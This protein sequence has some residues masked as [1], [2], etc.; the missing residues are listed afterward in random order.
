MRVTFL[1]NTAA[2]DPAGF[3]EDDDPARSPVV[4]ALLRLGYDVEPID[5][6]LNLGAVRERVEAF[7]PDVV[8]NR[9]E[10]LGGSDALAAAV[11]MLLDAMRVPYTGCPTAAIVATA[12][13]V[14]A[15]EQMVRAGLPTPDWLACDRDIDTSAFDPQSAIL[16][17]NYILK[18]VF[19]HASFEMDDTA[20]IDQGP[21]SEIVRLIEQRSGQC[22][23]PFF[24]EQFIE[25]RE[26]NLSLM[27]SEPEVLPPAE[28]DF[29]AFPEGKL[30]IV[31][32]GAKWSEASFEYQNTPRRFEFPA[33]DG[34]LLRRLSDLAVE[35]W[36]L[37]GLRGYA[38]VDFR[39]DAAGK[40][41]ILEVNTNPCIAPT[42]GFAA[43]MEQAG[44]SYDEGIRRIVGAAVQ[45]DAE[46][47]RQASLLS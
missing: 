23:K 19:E 28:I 11:P 3:A 2:E 27:D 14:A 46:R 38:R 34:P 8:F 37:F 17:P 16:N 26:F 35:C 30:R 42:S 22:G 12:N 45:P 32:F 6:T 24:A 47:V 43:A 7:E 20:V 39:V 29:S 18:S 40:P 21:Q 10:S 4:A 36:R 33:S 41:W 31:G 15:K 9:V 13:K 25:G 1:Y 44:L 5:C